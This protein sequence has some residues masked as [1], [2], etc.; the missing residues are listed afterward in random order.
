MTAVHAANVLAHE[1]DEEANDVPL[2]PRFDVFYLAKLGLAARRNFWRDG[3]GL[4]PR[5]EID[6]FEDSVR[7]RLEAKVN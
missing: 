2:P 4:P 5:D 1:T 3:C 6:T 7:R